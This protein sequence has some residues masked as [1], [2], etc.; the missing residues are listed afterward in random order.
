MSKKCETNPHD[1]VANK[2]RFILTWGLPAIL[3]VI[4]GVMQRA[5]M[6]TGTIWVVAL[7]WMSF[8]CL[9]NARHCGRMHCYFSGPFFLLGA[10]LTL[11][12]AMRWT[13]VLTLN[14]LGLFLL[15]GTPLV[16]ILPEVFWGTYKRHAH[17]KNTCDD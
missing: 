11:T 2:N 1:W 4:T 9:R 3:M 8:A 13:D 7:S 5:P 16:C 17:Q 15:I 6:V 14:E 12:T 10:V